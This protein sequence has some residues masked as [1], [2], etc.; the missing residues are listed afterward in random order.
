MFFRIVSQSQQEIISINTKC[1]EKQIIHDPSFTPKHTRNP[2]TLHNTWTLHEPY[3]EMYRVQTTSIQQW[4]L[5]VQWA[6]AS[7]ARHSNDEEH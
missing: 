6:Q 4:A 3:I 7:M 2:I 1:F 5:K